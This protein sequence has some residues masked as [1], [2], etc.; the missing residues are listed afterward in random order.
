[1]FACDVAWVC[2]RLVSG[3]IRLELS[4]QFEVCSEWN[5][6]STAGSSATSNVHKEFHKVKMQLTGS[7]VLLWNMPMCK[8]FFGLNLFLWKAQQILDS[9]DCLVFYC[10][11][12]HFCRYM[13][14]KTNLLVHV[15]FSHLPV[16]CLCNR[17]K[18]VCFFPVGG[19][20][21]EMLT[22]HLEEIKVHANSLRFR[23]VSMVLALFFFPLYFL[24]FQLEVNFFFPSL[25]LTELSAEAKAAL[26]EFE[27]R[28]RQ[29]KQGRYGSRRG[30]RRGGSIMCHGMG[31]QRRDNDRGRMKD[32]RPALLPNTPSTMVP[33]NP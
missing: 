7:S 16:L 28:E 11:A 23:D 26:L 32:H 4:T 19:V 8:T 17:H 14:G 21:N 10:V 2:I 5:L 15:C 20:I 25:F 13:T 31:E 12:W 6:G 3:C 9:K 24:C 18:C 29:L 22:C 30:G 33:F 1:M 27:E